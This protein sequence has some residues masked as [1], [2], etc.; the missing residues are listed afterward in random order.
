MGLEIINIA[1]LLQIIVEQ[2]LLKASFCNWGLLIHWS[3]SL[4][5]EIKITN[6]SST[7][8]IIQNHSSSVEYQSER[9][10]LNCRRGSSVGVVPCLFAL[11]FISWQ[12]PRCRSSSYRIW[13]IGW[14]WVT[15]KLYDCNTI[16]WFVMICMTWGERCVGFGMLQTYMYVYKTNARIASKHI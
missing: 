5:C 11:V 15:D 12:W 6:N 16:A 4:S 14:C 8:I 9:I 13:A 2:A 1:T 7:D 10:A 3:V